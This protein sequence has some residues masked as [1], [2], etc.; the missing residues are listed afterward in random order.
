MLATLLA[1]VTIDRW[2]RRVGLWWGAVGQ[3]IAMFLAGAFSHLGQ[4][5]RHDGNVALAE[6]YGAAAASFVFVFTSVFGATWLTVP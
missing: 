1:V 3:G 6:S 4:K 5:A 2:G